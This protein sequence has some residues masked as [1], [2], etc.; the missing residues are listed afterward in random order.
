[1]CSKQLVHLSLGALLIAAASACGSNDSVQLGSIHVKSQQIDAAAGGLISVVA[2]D[3]A[4]RLVGTQIQIPPNALA[5]S[6]KITIS[7][8]ADDLVDADAEVAGPTVD[9]GPDGTHFATPVRI[10][11]PYEGAADEDLFRVF[12]VSSNGDK[13]TLLPEDIVYD[14]AAKTVTF[15][16][17]HF[18]RFQ[19]GRG[20]HPCS[21]VR[22][23]NGTCHRGHCVGGSCNNPNACGPRP[24]V[25]SWMC[26]DG[27]VGGFT[28]RCLADAMGQCSWEINNCPQEC[29][30]M[31]C[32][33]PPPIANVICPNGMTT[34]GAIDCTRRADGTCGWDIT[35]CPTRCQADADCGMGLACQNGQ[36]VPPNTNQCDMN[37]VC[38]ATT[39]CQNGQ[40]VPITPACRADADCRMGESCVAGLCRATNPNQCMSD[41]ECGPGLTCVNGQCQQQQQTCGDPNTMVTCPAGSTCQNGMCVRNT[42]VCMSDRDCTSGGA[43]VNGQCVPV[44]PACRADSDC[45]MGDVC[46]NAQ[47]IPQNTNPCSDPAACGPRPALASWQCEDGSVGGFTGRCLPTPQSSMGQISCGWEFN[48]CPQACTMQECGPAPGLPT[49]MCSD[50]S[51]AGPGPCHRRADGSCGYDITQ[52]PT[53]TRCQTAMDCANGQV[54]QNNVCTSTPPRQCMADSNCATNQVCQNGICQ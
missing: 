24:G 31:E 11:L 13:Q 6:T 17:D 48:N 44:T 26:A 50:G 16:I 29:S 36:C 2:S 47:C 8:S 7:T 33:P 25:A 35:Q 52:C 32:G 15:S 54:C 28:G 43:C 45:P 34:T 49:V 5:A 51:T 20:R 27:S 40:C 19:P 46:V 10:T 21:H 53:T 18:T 14:A 22:C 41:A 12:V 38:P 39:T 3:G 4:P 9:F 37:H 42:P 23:P 30:P 1:M